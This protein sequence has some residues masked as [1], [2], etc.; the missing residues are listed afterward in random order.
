MAPRGL[1]RR[2]VAS[3]SKCQPSSQ[4]GKG[5]KMEMEGAGGR[6]ALLAKGTP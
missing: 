3:V 5:L 6:P 2:L 4:E 1:A